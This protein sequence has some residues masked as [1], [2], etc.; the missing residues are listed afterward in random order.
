MKS[1]PQVAP[2]KQYEKPGL[3]VYGNVEALTATVS[4]TAMFDGGG[5]AMNR[6]H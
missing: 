6:T 4:N 3:R 1:V 2:K 5:G